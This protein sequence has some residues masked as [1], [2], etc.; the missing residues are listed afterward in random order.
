MDEV[1]W[2]VEV[3]RRFRLLVVFERF[4]TLEVVWVLRPGSSPARSAN[5]FLL[6][7]GSGTATR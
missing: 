7:A 2:A 5:V 3:F 1:V 6:G 4:M